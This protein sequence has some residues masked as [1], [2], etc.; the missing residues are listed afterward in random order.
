MS[1]EVLDLS[2]QDN[3]TLQSGL[4]HQLSEEGWNRIWKPLAGH[5]KSTVFV[6]D[7]INNGLIYKLGSNDRVSIR[8]RL[9][10]PVAGVKYK[11][12]AVSNQSKTFCFQAEFIFGD[13]KPLR[14]M[15]QIRIR[16]NDKEDNEK[17]DDLAIAFVDGADPVR[18]LCY[19][20]KAYLDVA[21]KKIYLGSIDSLQAFMDQMHE[22]IEAVQAQVSHPYLT[23]EST[24]AQL[25]LPKEIEDAFQR[26]HEERIK[27]K[28]AVESK[29]HEYIQKQEVYK[30]KKL[31]Q[32]EQFDLDEL[33]LK[34]LGVTSVQVRLLMR[35][36]Q[37]RAEYLDQLYQQQMDLIEQGRKQNKELLDI[38]LDT[39]E[40][41][42]DKVMS[43][44]SGIGD[45]IQLLNLISQT[46]ATSPGT[47]MFD[48]VGADIAQK[49]FPQVTS[50]DTSKAETRQTDSDESSAHQRP[51]GTPI[52]ENV[53]DKDMNPHDTPTA[54][55]P[56]R[57]Q[58][59]FSSGAASEMDESEE[60][61]ITKE[62]ITVQ[63]PRFE[64]KADAD[65]NTNTGPA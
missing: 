50:G 57:R 46:T 32:S 16:I 39:I 61:S 31:E 20:I 64:E 4:V 33:E 35:D 42:R 62:D 65:S 7:R 10:H 12:F 3:F 14:T 58:R 53:S 27:H 48:V 13:T 30:V 52:A 23:L 19:S 45:L 51:E 24:T 22:T 29:E 40:K 63:S 17:Q 28:E 49:A 55:K 41:Y 25:E 34:R 36:P 56:K 5:P 59:R 1:N 11:A 60:P 47:N 54:P 44:H 9:V 18:E 26:R 15:L 8:S 38:R 21:F 6:F 37:K 2:T 43:E